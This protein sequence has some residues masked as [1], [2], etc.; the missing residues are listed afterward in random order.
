MGNPVRDAEK[1]AN[2]VVTVESKM[3]YVLRS[4]GEKIDLSHVTTS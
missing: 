1:G 3:L 4:E 2:K